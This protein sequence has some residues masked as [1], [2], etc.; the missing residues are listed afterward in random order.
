M[1]HWAVCEAPPTRCS[2]IARGALNRQIIITASA[3]R[4]RLG[5]RLGFGSLSSMVVVVYTRWRGG[6][7]NRV[8]GGSELIGQRCSL[9]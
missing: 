6:V 7:S 1:T 9:L 2:A 3:T 8:R 5:V 4:R